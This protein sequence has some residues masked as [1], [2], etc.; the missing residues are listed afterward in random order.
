[1]QIFNRRELDD[2]AREYGFNRDTFEKVCRLKMI[3]E[4]INSQ[5]N[6]KE[7]LLL[8]GG[9][10]I[11]LTVFKLPRLSVDIDLD[12]V[13]NFNKEETAIVRE[14]LTN[15]IKAYMAEQGYVL[16]DSSRFSHSLDAFHYY[17]INAA[18]NRDMIKIEINYSLRE[19]LFLPEERELLTEAFGEKITVKTVSAMEIFAA[20]TNALISRAAARDL[21]DFC[22][23]IESD[24]FSNEK[25]M[26]R[27]S[28]IFYA[29]ISAKEV[30]K[31][32]DTS[33]IDI[34]QFSNIRADLFPVLAVR[35]KFDLVGK[36]ESAKQYIKTLM[37]PTDNEIEY[38]NYF[39]DRQY[40]P[41][42]LFDDCEILGRIKTHPMALWKCR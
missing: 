42:L 8:K 21:Y 25:E 1:M 33:A 40:K 4:F 10:A 17:Y 19:H 29:T 9:T 16:S 35:D 31:E 14:Q 30:N 37:Q 24:L 18:G 20:K 22:N 26:F 13:P 27:K 7:H 41:E 32:F 39:V 28:I 6:L 23:L 5:K 11:N 38:M 3:L 36:K 34:L 12:F 15:I 2:R